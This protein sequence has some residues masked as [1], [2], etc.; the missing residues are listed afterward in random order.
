MAQQDGAA[1]RPIS[2]EG[3]VLLKNAGGILPLNAAQ[4]HSIALIGPFATHPKTGGGGSATVNPIYSIYPEA[5]LKSRVASGVA[6]T[7]KVGSHISSAMSYA[8]SLHVAI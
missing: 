2:E 4:L 6:S 1:E 7:R 8:A 3:M 5:G